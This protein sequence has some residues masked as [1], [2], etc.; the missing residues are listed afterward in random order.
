[1][2]KRV[3][4]ILL[5][6]IAIVLT[7]CV[8]PLVPRF[9]QGLE[10]TLFCVDPATKENEEGVDNYRE[11]VI[12][13]VDFFIFSGDQYDL[14]K[15]AKYHLRME[16]ESGTRRQ[17]T[18]TLRIS[19]ELASQE[20]I[21]V[22]TVVN[23]PDSHEQLVENGTS[24]SALYDR[25]ATADFVTPANHKQDR[26]LMSGSTVVEKPATT[27]IVELKRY[28]S[29]ITAFVHVEDVDLPKEGS[30]WEP[31][32][33]GME[34]YLENGNQCVKLGDP[35]HVGTQKDYYQ[36]FSYSSPK[37]DA[38]KNPVRFATKDNQTEIVKE[39]FARVPKDGDD[40]YYLQTY[41]MY[42]YP[43]T[44]TE[45]SID[46]DHHT[47]EPDIKLVV[48]WKQTREVP[49]DPSNPEGPKK[50]EVVSQKQCYYKIVMPRD[51]CGV[52]ENQG[53]FKRNFWYHFNIDIAILGAMTEGEAVDV[54][55][56]NCKIADWTTGQGNIQYLQASVGSARYLSIDRDTIDIRNRNNVSI[57]YISSHS[58]KIYSAY[59]SRPYYGEGGIKTDGD[60]E[61]GDYLVEGGLL[62]KEENEYYLEY[63]GDNNT[64]D[65][66]NWLDL[67]TDQDNS[68]L[69][70]THTLQNDYKTDN[71]DYSPY[72]I[73]YILVHKD[74]EIIG[75]KPQLSD[76]IT[77]VQYPAIFI[78]R[79]TNSDS[80]RIG[81]TTQYWPMKDG[82]GQNKTLRSDY[83]G[84]SFV[85]G[86]AYWPVNTTDP[87]ARSINNS[88]YCKWEAG[89]RQNRRDRN[90][91]KQDM[92]FKL[93]PDGESTSN[94]DPEAQ[95]RRREYQWRSIWYDGGTLDMFNIT[96]SSL[97]NNAY[98]IIGDPRT[99]TTRD[100]NQQYKDIDKGFEGYEANEIDDNIKEDRKLPKR[101]GFA[102]AP[103]LDGTRRTLSYY[104]PA[105]T[106]SRTINM[107]A[108]SFRISSKM[109]GTQF[110]NGGDTYYNLPG[111]SKEYAQ[112]RCATYQEDGFP[113]GRWR[114][115]TRAEVEFVFL[116]SANGAFATLFNKQNVYWSAN[117]AVKLKNQNN[118]SLGVVD[119]TPDQAKTALLRCVYDT[120]CWGEDQR[121]YDEWR[122][123][124]AGWWNEN[125]TFEENLAKVKEDQDKRQQLR[126]VFVWGDRLRN[127][128]E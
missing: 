9:G 117:G 78:D 59:A 38:V 75:G 28:A 24:L 76:T 12:S 127:E 93:G 124:D 45:G 92:F 22:F 100:L 94:P 90:T 109:S 96:V 58:L 66:A 34:L 108:P 84:Y 67:E 32:I 27:G 49:V 88:Q 102:E 43:Q 112:F 70:F 29:K 8:E 41:P 68:R 20:K 73:T 98:F 10:L 85:D 107:L 111:L 123:K 31:M 52:A 26:F 11:N 53:Q 115:P 44:W 51:I 87:F 80:D 47:C 126:N 120:W 83:W 104:Y 91:D 77:I 72:T 128:N 19:Y 3:F 36:Y 63:N 21:S 4:H 82:V 2:M 48:P 79:I 116:L 46:T 65:P 7:G 42:M 40:D 74:D 16:P 105:D 103:A 17:Y 81:G 37:K 14:S 119:A 113:A 18:F 5:Y 101:D 64:T 25:V 54:T 62:K 86:G 97:D 30:H 61:S 99:Y 71:F 110:A 95:A 33:E 15:E 118:P 1:M 106:T 125:M 89:A 57:S 56:V 121:E 55:P 13:W 50:K 6:F 35:D 122:M 60:L 69:T 114:L 39:I 23:Y